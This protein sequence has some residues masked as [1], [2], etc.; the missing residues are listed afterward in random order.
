VRRPDPTVSAL[1]VGRLNL[2][3][4]KLSWA[5]AGPTGRPVPA[6]WGTTPEGSTAIIVDRSSGRLDGAWS[7]AGRPLAAS[8]EVDV[9]PVPAALSQ[10]TL[11]VPGGLIL[12]ASAGDLAPPVAAPEPG[13]NEWRLNLGSQTSCRLRTA[14]PA[15]GKSARPL[16]LVRDNL[17]YY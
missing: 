7:L 14:P 2:N 11:R 13:W 15:D 5:A 4:S 17:N 9:E 16:I 6:L 1:S 3:V 12:T 8:T 10:L